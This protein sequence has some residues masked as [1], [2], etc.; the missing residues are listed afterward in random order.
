MLGITNQNDVTKKKTM[1]DGDSLLDACQR[2]HNNLK[3]Y[4]DCYE[5]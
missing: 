2:V 1:K 4:Q 5:N 3:G